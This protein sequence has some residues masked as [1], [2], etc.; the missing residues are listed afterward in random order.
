MLP[1]VT[2]NELLGLEM[3]KC[4]QEKYFLL[5]ILG[6]LCLNRFMAV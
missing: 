1:P 2:F 6:Q 4:F 3:A 5:T